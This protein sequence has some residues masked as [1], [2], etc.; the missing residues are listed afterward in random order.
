VS[1]TFKKNDILEMQYSPYDNQ[2]IVAKG[3]GSE[4]IKIQGITKKED[5]SLRAVVFLQNRGDY[6]YLLD[7]DK[8]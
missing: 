1:F 6:L 8:V 7:K 2:L 3:N 4:M 5:R